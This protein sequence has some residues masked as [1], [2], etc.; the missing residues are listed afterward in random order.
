ME[1]IAGRVIELTYTAEDMAPWAKSVGF[2]GAPFEFDLLRR[3]QL[4]AE[5]DAFY[6]RK[7]GLNREE[8]RYILDPSDVKGEGYPSETFAVL[9]RNE[10]REHGEY[11]TQRLVLEAWDK[12][13]RGELH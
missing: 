12:L 9:K 10:I 5:L 11:R 8:L 13:E 4:V 2:N 6:A 7:Y 1:F 3:A